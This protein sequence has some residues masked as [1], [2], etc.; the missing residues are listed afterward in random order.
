[1]HRHKEL[2]MTDMDGTT[3]LDANQ[4]E[5]QN[6]SDGSADADLQSTLKALNERLSQLEGQQR[7]LQSGKDRGIAGLQDEVHK[8]Q[9]NFAEILEYGKRY[10]DPTEAERNY[11]I[12]QFLKTV[13]AGQAQATGEAPPSGTAYQQAGNANV[14]PGVL[15]NYGVDPQSPEY[16]AQIKAG[17]SSFEASLAVLAGKA[18]T[19]PQEGVASGASGGAGTGSTAGGSGN[20]RNQAM[21]L[22]QYREEVDKVSKDN[23]GYLSPRQLYFIQEKYVTNGLDREAIG[24]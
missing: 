5:N 4:G 2:H 6:H 9:T 16:L 13:V 20:E 24:W 10:S 8:M 17:K 12:D 3:N 15:A 22:A 7:A 14:D 18:G 21:L 23:G 19:G 11:R 1:M